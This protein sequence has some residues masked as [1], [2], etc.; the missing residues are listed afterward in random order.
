MDSNVKQDVKEMLNF[1]KDK[2]IEKETDAIVVNESDPL[3]SLKNVLFKFFEKRLEVIQQEEGFKEEVKDAIREKINNNELSPA[4]L[5]KLYSD[6]SQQASFSTSSI[7]DI[8]KPGKDGGVS[9]L[10]QQQHEGVGGVQATNEYSEVTPEQADAL[11]NLKELVNK[12]YQDSSKTK[13]KN[14]SEEEKE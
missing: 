10:V 1:M 5:M 8:F 3:F 7:L 14:I 6:I 13:Q 11:N 4:Q 9:P 12:I 2:D